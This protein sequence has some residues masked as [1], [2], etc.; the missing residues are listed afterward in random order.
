[1]IFITLMAGLTVQAQKKQSPQIPI[2]DREIF[3]GDPEITGA[4]LSPN[5]KFMSFIKPF[6]GTRNIWVK[7]ATDPFESAKPLTEDTKRPISSYFWSRDSKY[8]LYTQDKGGNENYMIYAVNP[9][10]KP[11]ENQ[12]VPTSRNLTNK[13][14]VRA[15]IYA[16][17]KSNPDL[18]YVG[19]N[20]RDASWHDLYE[21]KI[22]TGDLK[23]VRQNTER[24]VS[25]IFDL[26]DKLRLAIRS[27]E[28]GSSELLR[29]DPKG[30]TKIYDCTILEDFNP[31]RFHPDGLR[32]YMST[33]KGAKLNL[34]QLILFNIQTK[35]EEM[36]ETDPLK[37]VDFG[38]VSFS[39]LTNQI[40]ATNYED[41]K[42][43]H[44]WKDKAMENEY[45]TLKKQFKGKEVNF[46]SS[47]K[48][49]MTWLI[50]VYSDTDPGSVYLYDRRTKKTTFQYTPR[51]KMPIEHLAS[52]RVIKYKSSDG[53]VIPAYLTLPKGLPA[54]KLPLIINPHGGPWARDGWGYD[55]FAQF[56]ANRGYAVLQVNFRGSTGYGKKFLDAGNKQWGDLM[57]DD[58]TWGVKHLVSKGV[59]DPN[60]VGIF[61][62]SYGGYAALAGLTFTP[63]VYA[64]GISLVGPSSL[65]TLLKSIPPY[66]EAGRKIF[67]ERMGDPTTP[68]GEEQL[69]RQSP[70]FSVASINDPL[71]VVQGANDPR[72]KKAE[73]DQIVIAMR[74]KGLPVEYICAPDEGHGFARPVNNMAFLAAA[75]KFLAKHLRGRY[76][77]TMT[78]DIAKRLKEITID[79]ASI[80]LNKPID[81]EEM[82]AGAAAVVRDLNPGEYVYEVEMNLMGEDHLF[83]QT[84][85]VKDE[86][87]HWSVSEVMDMPFGESKDHTTLQ[88]GN[89]QVLTRYLDQG[90]VNLDLKFNGQEVNGK[91]NVS[92]TITKIN[93]KTLGPSLADGPG[94]LLVLANLPLREGYKSYFRNIDLQKMEEKMMSLEVQRSEIIDGIDCFVA[95]IKPSN[96]DPGEINVWVTK[97][98]PSKTIKYT[99]TIPEMEGATLKG[100][101]K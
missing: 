52:M 69:K 19:L 73:S 92:G 72:V 33:N 2:I 64:C 99:M 14:N 18:M 25:W 17:P 6:K 90:P 97:A 30:F 84:I 46:N 44:Y 89:L 36:V 54:K 42:T 41:D 38:W 93:I 24:M 4:Q 16:V 76:Q 43:R 86:G 98:I 100:I 80:N 81:K 13:E 20:D 47:T 65:L 40:I 53:L 88:K 39:D 5:G 45:K 49:E 61:G 7:K 48:D 94:L 34:S 67:H 77:E 75:E 85:N 21:L 58:L 29:I 23:L 62:G 27:N 32:I 70:L 71:L 28:D 56:L 87:S 91:M 50:G 79:P 101:L 31:I 12:Q 59:A 26:K 66:W 8:I 3:F 96:G 55:P 35:K 63:D 51:P 68:E 83:H 60:R 95:T 57:Q 15:Y 9:N 82:I 74:D 10:E 11:K 37:K 78:D 22:S 1:M